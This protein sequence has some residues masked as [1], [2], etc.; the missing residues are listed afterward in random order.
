MDKMKILDK[1]EAVIDG[2]VAET[3][4][5][6]SIYRGIK[7]LRFMYKEHARYRDRAHSKA[8]A[9]LDHGNDKTYSKW[10][11]VYWREERRARLLQDQLRKLGVSDKLIDTT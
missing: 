7:S 11:K 8:K 2:M 3:A 10:M 5:L 6:E 9:A 4:L 1:P